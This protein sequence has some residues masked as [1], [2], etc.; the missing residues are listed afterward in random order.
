[1][2]TSL[3]ISDAARGSARVLLAAIGVVEW[4][5]ITIPRIVRGPQ[6]AT[7]FQL[8]LLPPGHAHPAV[9]R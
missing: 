4:G 6:T 3:L 1:V 5:G 2:E 7:L 9:L 8:R